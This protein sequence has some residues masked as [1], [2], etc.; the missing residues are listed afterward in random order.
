MAEPIPHWLPPLAIEIAEVCGLDALLRLVEAYG[1]IAI[2]VPGRHGL[3]RVLTGPPYERFVL[4]FRGEELLIPKLEAGRWQ[5]KRRRVL[6]LRAQGLTVAQIARAQRLTE[7]QVYRHLARQDPG[8]S[9]QMSLF[10]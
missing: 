8:E 5:L 3:E 10:E 1:G 6:E 9:V 7:R 4:H 2:R